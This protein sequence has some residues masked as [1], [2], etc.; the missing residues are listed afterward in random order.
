[1]ELYSV[2]WSECPEWCLKEYGRFPKRYST[3]KRDRNSGTILRNCNFLRSRGRK[4]LAKRIPRN[5]LRD[6]RNAKIIHDGR[7]KKRMFLQIGSGELFVMLLAG[8]VK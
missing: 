2:V 8:Q 5:Y 6:G 3:E 7:Q 1:M 4:E